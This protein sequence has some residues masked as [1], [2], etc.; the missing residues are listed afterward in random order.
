[1]PGVAYG[2]GPG[3]FALDP[4][5][6]GIDLAQIAQHGAQETPRRRGRAE[7]AIGKAFGYRL[8]RCTLPPQVCLRAGY[9]SSAGIERSPCLACGTMYP[10]LPLEGS[11]MFSPEF[12]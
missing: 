2:A 12:Y 11:V 4:F 3:E 9:D 6:L 1:M 7:A 5:E 8:C 10:E